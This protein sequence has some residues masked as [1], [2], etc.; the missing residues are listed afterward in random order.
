MV[1]R[2]RVRDEKGL[3][4]EVLR[5]RWVSTMRVRAEKGLSDEGEG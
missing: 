4:D 2:M 3:D 5:L 1:S